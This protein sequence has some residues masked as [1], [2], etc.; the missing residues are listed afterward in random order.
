M[1]VP[2]KPLPVLS[3]LADVQQAC[4][5]LGVGWYLFGALAAL[6][7]GSPRLTA[8]AEPTVQLGSV[9]TQELAAALNRRG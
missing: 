6:L 3:L 8:D 1:T 7:Y 2:R 9:S 5:E 4:A